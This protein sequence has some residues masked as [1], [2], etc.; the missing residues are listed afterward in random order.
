[1]T[2]TSAASPGSTSSDPR[3]PIQAVSTTHTSSNPLDAIG[4][5]LPLP[6]PVPDWSK[7]IILLLIALALALGARAHNNARR[8]RRLEAQRTRLLSDVHAMQVALVPEVPPELAATGI[9]V[10]YRPADG[11]AA[12]GDFYDVFELDPGRVALVLGDVCGH[13]REA[14]DRAALT[15]YTIRAYLQAGL[16][17][18]AALA[19]AGQVLADPTCLHFATV[20]AGVYDS[21]TSRLTYASAG[22]PA[23]IVLGPGAHVPVEECCSPPVGWGVP[24]G[25]R[26]TSIPL[27]ATSAVCFFTDGLT[28]ARCEDG[29][30]GTERLVRLLGGL[31]PRPGAS[32]LVRRVTEEADATPDDMA[33]CVLVSQTANAPGPRIEE[34]ELD[35]KALDGDAVPRFLAA[36][37][38]DEN[39]AA[40]LITRAEELLRTATTAVVR[41]EIGNGSSRALVFAPED[42]SSY[43]LAGP[44]HG[45]GVTVLSPTPAHA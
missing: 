17:P 30:L 13:G 28:E 42:P 44:S 4:G 10:A 2:P 18:R 37:G 33:A 39:E 25:R 1:M 3:A 43:E 32:D 22:H 6:L 8:A 12:G 31:G 34:L 20:L 41:I 5:R 24:T 14:L 9:S 40:D 7:P 15:R 11:A 19:L 23:P 21:S 16:E 45:N 38:L 27:P 35:H 29:L 36:C 26:Q